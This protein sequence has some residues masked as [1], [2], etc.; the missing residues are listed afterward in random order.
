MRYRIED[1][2]TL[3]DGEPI[4]T[5]LRDRLQGDPA[6][7]AALRDLAARRNALAALPQ[8][9]PDPTLEARVLAAMHD[10]AGRS[11]TRRRQW[12]AV[13]TAATLLTMAVLL[14]HARPAESP[15]LPPTAATTPGAPAGQRVR[16][17]R[18]DYDRLVEQSALLEGLLV[19]LP[20]Q[21]TVMSAGTASTI[22]SLEDQVA[23][24]DARLVL[25]SV[26]RGPDEFRTEL[27]R[28]RVDVMNALLQVRYAQSRL[29]AY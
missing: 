19:A 16:Y 9:H 25:A 28:E 15:D 10:T 29:F 20:A 26:A 8:L 2:L 6:A 5:A 13:A 24:I 18:A 23:A 11:N 17:E 12:L 7:A 4:D 14:W 3:R 1:L 22:A 27:W 21:R